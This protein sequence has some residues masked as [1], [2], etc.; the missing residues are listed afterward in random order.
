MTHWMN[1][2]ESCVGTTNVDVGNCYYDV[3]VDCDCGSNDTDWTFDR[4]M[5]KS[6]V[7][8]KMTTMANLYQMSYVLT[9]LI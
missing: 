9:Y 1:T 3:C 8:M 6:I 2:D 7:R 4:P 5:K